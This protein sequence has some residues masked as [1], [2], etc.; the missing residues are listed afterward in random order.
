[1]GSTT[2]EDSVADVGSR[3]TY[4]VEILDKNEVSQCDLHAFLLAHIAWWKYLG[5]MREGIPLSQSQQW[6]VKAFAAQTVAKWLSPNNGWTCGVARDRTGKIVAC[7]FYTGTP[8]QEGDHNT[9][10]LENCLTDRSHRRRGLMGRL[11]A[12][13]VTFGRG[14]GFHR[15]VAHIRTDTADNLEPMMVREGFTKV[16]PTTVQSQR[17]ERLI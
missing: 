16:D 11:V 15:A 4:T 2:H 5:H 14:R 12:Q 8:P 10:S 13:G 3:T 7:L 1:M 9:L 17:F 6:K